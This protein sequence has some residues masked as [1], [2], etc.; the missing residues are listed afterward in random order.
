MTKIMMMFAFAAALAAAAGVDASKSFEGDIDLTQMSTSEVEMS[1]GKEATKEIL[2]I[3]DG[4]RRLRT[5]RALGAT[6]N[7]D[8]LWKDA[9]LF[10]T[11]RSDVSQRGLQLILTAMFVIEMNTCF[12]FAERTDQ[13]G[14]VEFIE[15]DVCQSPVGFQGMKMT[16]EAGATCSLGS[17]MHEILHAMG[18]WHEQSRP[19]RDSF[20]TI[21]EENIK[22]GEAHNFQKRTEIDS[23]GTIYDYESIMHYSS[24]AFSKNGLRTI[25]SA[26]KK[27]WNRKMGNREKLS[28]LDIYQ[29]IK[30]YDLETIRPPTWLGKG[31]VCPLRPSFCIAD[32]EKYL[33]LFSQYISGSSLVVKKKMPPSC[34]PEE[35]EMV[36]GKC[37]VGKCKV[38]YYPKGHFSGRNIKVDI[39]EKFVERQP[40][41][42]RGLT[43]KVC[44]G[45]VRNSG[46]KCCKKGSMDQRDGKCYM[47]P[48]GYTIQDTMCKHEYKLQKKDKTHIVSIPVSTAKPRGSFACGYNERWQYYDGVLHNVGQLRALRCMEDGTVKLTSVSDERSKIEIVAADKYPK[49][50]AEHEVDRYVIRCVKTNTFISGKW[51]TGLRHD[52]EALSRSHLFH[53]AGGLP[54]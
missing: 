48:D 3:Y 1:Y 23:M 16:V 8:L 33:N 47:C 34:A 27:K 13:V 14:Y 52:N 40:G 39:C 49:S 2:S 6:N 19:D 17:N 30:R 50:I 29:V 10:Y 21:H 37:L 5:G 43:G 42:F 44:N 9:T 32:N 22:N 54:Q 38:G 46:G 25:T 51:D 26:T 45:Q 36:D 7:K 20:V 15:T 35:E 4:N 18:F 31:F 11:I 41:K 53:I 24:R 12:R 28:N